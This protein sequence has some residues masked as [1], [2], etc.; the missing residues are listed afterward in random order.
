MLEQGLAWWFGTAGHARW[1]RRRWGALL[2]RAA[3]GVRPGRRESAV[4]VK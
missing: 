4:R 1:S 2:A 3:A